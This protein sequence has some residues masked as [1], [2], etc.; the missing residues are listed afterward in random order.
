MAGTAPLQ[1]STGED[2]DPP[3]MKLGL[4]LSSG[5]RA[6][7]SYWWRSFLD[8][9]HHWNGAVAVKR[10][11]RM[12]ALRSGACVAFCVLLTGCA[13]S[14]PAYLPVTLQPPYSTLPEAPAGT[15]I[16]PGMPVK[17]NAQQQEAVIAGVRK[18][19]KDPASASFGT[20][21]AARTRRGGIV[22]CGEV[23]G[24]N[25][26]GVLAPMAP[27]IGVLTPSSSSSE[28]VVVDIA[29]DGKPRA[30]LEALC[31]QSGAV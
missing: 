5:R 29:A 23:A 12:S 15:T 21:A 11:A 24:L 31:R 8:H 27:F 2:I 18:W 9:E 13:Q 25:S 17:L 16:E 6:L 30:E 26:A 20:M 10:S 14:D 22:V 7:V 1:F 4:S 28:F 3:R 19:M